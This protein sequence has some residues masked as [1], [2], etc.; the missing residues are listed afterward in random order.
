MSPTF[1]SGGCSIAKATARAIASGGIAIS[2]RRFSDACLDLGVRHR[3][4][5][6]GS[7]EAGRHVGHAQLAS[8]LERGSS[9]SRTDSVPLP[10]VVVAIRRPV[11]PHHSLGAEFSVT[12]LPDVDAFTTLSAV[13]EWGRW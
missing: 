10:R 3:V 4:G 5:K 7:N 2:S 9:T 13:Y 12:A 11:G 8:R 6:R 1:T